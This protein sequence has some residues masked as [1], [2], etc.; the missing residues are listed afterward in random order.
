MT[1]REHTHANES[2][3]NWNSVRVVLEGL[4]L[5]GLCWAIN[6]QTDQTKAIV[7]LQTQIETIQ[8][9]S[10]TISAAIPTLAREVDKLDLQ[11]ADHER[12]IAELEQVKGGAR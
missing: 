12:R 8:A 10:Q 5:A 1:G 9:S 4:I 2:A 7:K 3:R 6:N 11:T